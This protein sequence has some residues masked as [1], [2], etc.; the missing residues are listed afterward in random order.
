M[1]FYNNNGN[2]CTGSPN[3]CLFAYKIQESG[4]VLNILF[5]SNFEVVL[6]RVICF[7]G[8]YVYQNYNTIRQ[9][10][11]DK[12]DLFLVG[13]QSQFTKNKTPLYVLRPQTISTKRVPR[14][15]LAIWTKYFTS[16]S[17]LL[18]KRALAW[19]TQEIKYQ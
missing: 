13:F 15:A 8:L 3:L 17:I 2:L 14:Q 16:L 9:L 6:K 7:G 5:L 1:D 11:I 12:T 10:K 4:N 19:G 18:D